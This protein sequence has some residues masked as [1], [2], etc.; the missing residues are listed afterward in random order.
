VLKEE[1]EKPQRSYILKE[2]IS[3]PSDRLAEK[4]RLKLI[5]LV[6]MSFNILDF[7][8]FALCVFQ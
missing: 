5:L 1:K 2:R 4:Q 3:H 7:F 6:S 8:F